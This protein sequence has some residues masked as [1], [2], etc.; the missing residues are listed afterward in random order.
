[1]A[2]QLMERKTIVS[3]ARV[4]DKDPVYSFRVVKSFVQLV[5]KAMEVGKNPV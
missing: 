4:L 2:M 5:K 3:L 1:M